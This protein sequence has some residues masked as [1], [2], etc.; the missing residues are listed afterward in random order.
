MEILENKLKPIF[1]ENQ[2]PT[3]E[4]DFVKLYLDDVCKLAGVD[5]KS[6][7]VFFQLL[8][9]ID[10]KSNKLHNVVEL[11]RS[12]KDIIANNLGLVGKFE[13][14]RAKKYL[15]N[16]YLIKLERKGL[17]KKLSSDV[18]LINPFI[19]TKVDWNNTVSLRALTLTITYEKSCRTLITLVEEEPE[20]E[21]KVINAINRNESYIN[22][23]EE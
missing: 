6:Q 21:S 5:S 17:I 7:L 1:I 18:Y 12:R 22:L 11:N 9:F 16:N 15:I 2:L 20:L 4:P 10:P 3:K 23:T 13:D 19:A 8:N 14:G